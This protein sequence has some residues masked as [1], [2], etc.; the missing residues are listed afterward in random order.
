MKEAR[1]K[2]VSHTEY[3]NRKNKSMQLEIKLVITPGEVPMTMSFLN[4]NADCMVHFE[5]SSS[6]H[7]EVW[8]Q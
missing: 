3:K 8:G 4:T 2:E 5:K 7:R 6:N 1:L